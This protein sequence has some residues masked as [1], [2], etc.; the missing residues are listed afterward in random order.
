M[1]NYEKALVQVAAHKLPDAKGEGV[2]TCQL[3]Q[4]TA[5]TWNGAVAVTMSTNVV[6]TASLTSASNVMLNVEFR[7]PNFSEND[8]YNYL[9]FSLVA[10]TG[11]YVS[12][13]VNKAFGKNEPVLFVNCH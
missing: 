4:S 13:I 9:G 12:A 5:S 2:F 6:G 11:C 10:P 8:N 1:T 3:Y 7:Q